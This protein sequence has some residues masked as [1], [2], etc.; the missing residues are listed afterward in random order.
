MSTQMDL[1]FPSGKG[2]VLDERDREAFNQQPD[3]LK[4][5]HIEGIDA[6][7]VADDAHPEFEFEEIEY[8]YRYSGF[9][10]A[11]QDVRAKL[12]EIMNNNEYRVNVRVFSNSPRYYANH[13]LRVGGGYGFPNSGFFEYNGVRGFVFKTGSG[14]GRYPM[15]VTRSDHV[16][17]FHLDFFED[18]GSDG[19]QHHESY[20]ANGLALVGD[21]TLVG[22]PQDMVSLDLGNSKWEPTVNY[23]DS[24][25]YGDY[26]DSIAFQKIE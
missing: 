22:N 16:I 5:L 1:H 19:H 25:E 8:G 17:G 10:S 9:E 24:D 3:D 23:Y 6:R 14:S 12:R 15:F 18:S 2:I 21:L 4:H 7:H 13:R 20:D 11:V 26:I